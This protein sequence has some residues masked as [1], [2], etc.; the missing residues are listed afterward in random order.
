MINHFWTF[1][2]QTKEFNI[3]LRA[4]VTFLAVSLISLVPRYIVY[5]L[6]LHYGGAGV[7]FVPDIANLGGIVAG[8]IVNF[9]GSKYFVF[10]EKKDEVS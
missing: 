5:S 7:R 1:S 6:I 2:T 8:T 9:I 4:F 3:S 10:K